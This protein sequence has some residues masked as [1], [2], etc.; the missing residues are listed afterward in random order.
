MEWQ[1]R[2]QKRS[3]FFKVILLCIFLFFPRLFAD[4]QNSTDRPQVLKK[5]KMKLGEK[6]IWVEVARTPEELSKGLMYRTSL[7]KDSGMLFVFP[8]AEMLSFWMKNTLI[9]LSIGFFDE[10]KKLMEVLEMQT[11]SVM[12]RELP[13]YE[14]HK[15]ARYA[16]E[17]KKNWFSENKIKKGARLCCFN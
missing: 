6:T 9:P 12:Q 4:Q 7:D 14:S 11:T 15:P 17:M 5:E 2:S 3:H 8:A 16:L 1:C 10:N 13:R